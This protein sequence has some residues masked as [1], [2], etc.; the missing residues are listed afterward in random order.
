MKKY[1][2]NDLTAREKLRLL[3]SNGFWHTVDFD[4][5][6]SVRVRVRRARGRA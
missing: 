4:G 6:L 3:C 2:V 1:T 5:K